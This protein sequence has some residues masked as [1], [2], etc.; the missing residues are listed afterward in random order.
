MLRAARRPLLVAALAVGCSSSTAPSAG[1]TIPLQKS[2]PWPKFRGNAAQTGASAVHP[3]TTGGAQWA[4]PTAHGIFSSPVVGADGTIY[5]GSADQTF[6]ALNP[7][8]TT[9]FSVP[10]GEIID[11]AALLDDRGRVY[12]GSGDGN[13]RAL[14][15]ATGAVVWT[16]PADTPKTTGA[17]INWFE[18]NVAI[19]PTGTL[20]VPN[21]NFWVYA[22]DRD[23]GTPIWHYTMP[24]Q[25][26]SLP[27]VDASSGSLFIG[28]NNLLPILGK[29]TFGIAPDGTTNWSM[30]SLGTVAASPLLTPDG[31]VIVGG[32]DG[33]ARA[34]SAAD[35][36]VLWE[37]PTRDHIYSSPARELDGTLV[38][39]SADGTIYDLSP[40]DGHVVWS[41]DAGTPIRSSPAVD[42]DGNVYV[43]G[44]DGRLYV[45]RAD[46]TLRWAMKL[47]DDPRNDLNS[48]PALGSDAVY[49]G[50]ESGAMF[51]V[52]Y[53][54]CLRAANA[55]D[56]RCTTSLPAALDGASLAWITPFGDTLATAPDAV[57]ANAPMTFLLAVRQGGAEQLDILD[58]S[59]ITATLAPAGDVSVDVSGDGKFLTLTPN[60]PLP[61]GPLTIALHASYL[62]DLSR[63]GLALSGG[64]DGG[65]VDATFSTTVNASTTGAIVPSATY[66]IS[67]LSIPL[68][69][70]MP[71][72]NQIGFDSLHYLLGTISLTNGNG[73]A[74]M[75]G[76]KLPS[77]GAASVPDPATQAIFPLTLSTTGDAATFE[78][79]DGLTVQIMSFA[80]PFHSFRLAMRFTTTGDPDGTTTLTGSAVCA[81]IN[82]YG[83]F[84]EQLGL[85]NPQTDVVR[86]LGAANVATRT[87]L[88]PPPP[89]GTVT[90]DST[91]SAITATVTGSSVNINDHLAALL[92]IDPTTSAP[93]TLG[94]GLGTTRTSAPDGTLTG[95]SV[96]TTGATIP[97][98]A[99]VYLMIDTTVAAMGTLP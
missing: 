77:A 50:G 31:K 58:T 84:L 25:T 93:V 14:D 17:F 62:T 36:T 16:M 56:A 3:A 78:A 46:G 99:V 45:L 5:F 35:G 43:G 42:G 22:V 24:D 29:N 52:P 47:I 19:A 82:F 67:R 37:A 53:D 9:R 1:P 57:D 11:S 72:Y 64:H 68:P 79:S 2:S 65:A 21:D 30:V 34:Y 95:V 94:Y 51:S 59:S 92:V 91:S 27:A 61:S 33:Y 69:T 63:T 87:D 76:A 96:P 60:A 12:F 41:F 49:L 48:S 40:V 28:N 73:L 89:V 70:L 80:L 4:F 75:I 10:T 6:Y 97:P 85:C 7:D 44:G 8:G 23:T 98:G 32:F 15:A 54:W 86:F 26:W 66:E 88:Q 90:F 13:L 71:S 74:W 20:Y 81:N 55:Q 39:P 18:G 83:P 38:Q